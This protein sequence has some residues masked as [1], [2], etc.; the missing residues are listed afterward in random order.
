MTLV[1]TLS[2]VGEP[3]LEGHILLQLAAVPHLDCLII[4]GT[5]KEHAIARNSQLVHTLPVL[6]QMAHQHP[7]GVPRGLAHSTSSC[8]SRS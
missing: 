2:C 8:R 7:L 1:P 3:A 4:A 5:G 6:S